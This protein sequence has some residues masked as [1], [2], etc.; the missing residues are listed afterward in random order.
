MLWLFPYVGESFADGKEVNGSCTKPHTSPK[1]EI[2]GPPG[3]LTPSKNAVS[4]IPITSHFHEG[5]VAVISEQVYTPPP[6]IARTIE[7]LAG[8][9]SIQ[10]IQLTRPFVQAMPLLL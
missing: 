1:E 7:G 5:F 9:N 10:S 4:S 3:I 6:P 2:N 8:S